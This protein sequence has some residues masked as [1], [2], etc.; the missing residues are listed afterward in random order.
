[1]LFFEGYYLSPWI[2]FSL[3]ILGVQKVF[4]NVTSVYVIVLSL[5]LVNGPSR[6]TVPELSKLVLPTFRPFIS[7]NTVTILKCT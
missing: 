6:A 7:G 2:G 3:C 4:I 5:G 1:M